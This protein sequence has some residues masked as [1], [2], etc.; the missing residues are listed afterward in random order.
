M[1]ISVELIREEDN[2]T[3]DE[4]T[5]EHDNQ[6]RIFASHISISGNMEYGYSTDLSASGSN[7]SEAMICKQPD[8]R[9]HGH[10]FDT[11]L[12]FNHHQPN[13]DEPRTS[14]LI[15]LRA[16]PSPQVLFCMF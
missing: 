1:C 10:G 11:R 5:K 3:D 6:V 16:T 14:H 12:L 7:G 9:F 4:Q 15:R 13:H 8:S 2:E